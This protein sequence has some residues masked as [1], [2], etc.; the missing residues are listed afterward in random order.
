M[1]LEHEALT[2]KIIGAAI[3]VHRKLGPGFIESIYENALMIELVNQGLKV[4]NQVE[5]PVH[6]NGNLVGLHRLDMIVE[7]TVILELK[8]ISNFED[9]HFAVLKSYLRATGK[10]H[11][12]LLNFGKATLDMKRVLVKEK[13]ER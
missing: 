3:E 13:K 12:L 10:N 11:G 4:K 7:D 2:G 8:A 6:Y 5:V 1:P 9:I